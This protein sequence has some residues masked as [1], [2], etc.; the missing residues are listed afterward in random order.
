MAQLAMT[1]W[2]S[3]L[4][5]YCVVFRVIKSGN[6]L[7]KLFQWRAAARNSRP[8]GEFYQSIDNWVCFNRATWNHKSPQFPTVDADQSTIRYTKLGPPW[9]LCRRREHWT[10]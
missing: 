5:C 10:F 7:C 2:N 4:C 3:L 8:W 1:F 9:A 6:L